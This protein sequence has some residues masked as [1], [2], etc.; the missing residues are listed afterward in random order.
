MKLVSALLPFAII[1]GALVAY[2]VGSI[3]LNNR[4]R[5]REVEMMERGE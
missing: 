1:V 2:V 5:A 3:W 4:K